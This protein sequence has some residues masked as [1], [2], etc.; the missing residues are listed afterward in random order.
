M[1]PLRLR[2]LSAVCAGHRCWP[3]RYRPLSAWRRRDDCRTGPIVGARAAASGCGMR[4]A[5][6]GAADGGHRRGA[7]YW[8]HVV[9]PRLSGRCH[10]RCPG[11]AACRLAGCM[12][13]LR[14][15]CGALSGGLRAYRAAR[16]L[17]S[18]ARSR[19][20]GLGRAGMSFPA[21]TRNDR[22][23]SVAIGLPGD[24]A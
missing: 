7:V 24:R 23:A 13:R 8:L 22:A 9:H 12:Y 20:S 5:S 2:R 15:V 4:G 17:G 3:S 21:A 14:F 18:C 1:R 19:D 6:S 16:R 10:C 11:P